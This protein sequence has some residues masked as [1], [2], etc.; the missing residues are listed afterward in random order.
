[1]ERLINISKDGKVS[2]KE[3]EELESFHK[4]YLAIV[5][6]RKFGYRASSDK[7]DDWARLTK[8]LKENI[9]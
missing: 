1:M 6:Q 3:L 4:E 9:T 8:L 5:S 7:N 2:Q